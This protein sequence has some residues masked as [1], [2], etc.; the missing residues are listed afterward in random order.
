ME[1][2][3]SV[4][5]EDESPNTKE[6]EVRFGTKSK[7]IT[8]IN[9][10]GV[11][12]KLLSLGFVFKSNHPETRLRINLD[13]KS[14]RCDIEGIESISTYCKTNM[15]GKL[16]PKS[17]NFV[18]KQSMKDRSGKIF[19]TVDNDD[20]SFRTSLQE[21]NIIESL[22]VHER[23]FAEWKN[24]KKMFRYISRLSLVH[25]DFPYVRVILP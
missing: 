19:E 5:L 24:T 17:Y 13:K 18:D 25:K 2:L 11:I 6:F 4:Y 8:K 1:K 14:V 10:D 15:L 12:K 7:N 3:L 16:N 21:E 20:F 22:E 9:Y 23:I